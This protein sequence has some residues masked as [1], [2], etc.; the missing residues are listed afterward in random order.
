MGREH[1]CAHVYIIL[2]KWRTD[3]ILLLRM[4]SGENDHFES[5][6]VMRLY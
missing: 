6:G 2:A 3:M 5:H 1:A 4:V